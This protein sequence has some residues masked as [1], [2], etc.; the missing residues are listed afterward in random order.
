VSGFAR[1]LAVIE[2]FDQARGRHYTLSLADLDLIARRQ[3]RPGRRTEAIRL[4][5]DYA[6]AAGGLE[7]AHLGVDALSVGRNSLKASIETGAVVTSVI[8]RKILR[9]RS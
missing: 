2:A 6:D 1:G 4:K 7:L 5:P 9:Q 8:L 3:R